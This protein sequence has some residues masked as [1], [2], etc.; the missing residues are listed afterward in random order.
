MIAD[1]LA[2]TE[3]DRVLNRHLALDMEGKTSLSD[4]CWMAKSV[5][6]IV[7]RHAP[8][9]VP[10]GLLT[11]SEWFYN[12]T[13]RRTFYP[14]RESLA[15]LVRTGPA[16]FSKLGIE[17]ARAGLHIDDWAAKNALPIADDASYYQR[18]HHIA[19]Y[20]FPVVTNEAIA[21]IGNY[22]GRDAP[23]LEVGAGNGY[24]ACEMQAR[25][26]SVVPTDP[27]TAGGWSCGGTRLYADIIPMDG[28]QAVAQYAGLDMVYSWPEMEEYA[29]EIIDGFTGR[30]LAYLGEEENG[31][32]GGDSFHERLESGR[33]ALVARAPLPRFRGIYDSL[34]IYEN[35][36]R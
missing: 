20:G 21:L 4:W 3:L 14:V 30:Y 8:A 33:F 34:F 15:R 10:P 18:K 16:P 32:T 1:L 31:C 7:R 28:R 5:A 24:L 27:N 23:I 36:H 25:G 17:M 12:T 29:T 19:N 26:F 6:A 35:Q 2:Q 11:D 22:M 13:V 9:T